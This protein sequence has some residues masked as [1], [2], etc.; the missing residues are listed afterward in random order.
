MRREPLIRALLRSEHPSIR[1]RVRTGALGE[2]PTSL[3]LRRLQGQIR[4][5]PV[6]KA[7]LARRARTGE[8]HV[9]HNPYDTCQGAR[10]V[11]GRVAA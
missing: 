5:S 2:D 7:L 6:A 3:A 1:W 8:F 11:P 10:G 9:R 4:K